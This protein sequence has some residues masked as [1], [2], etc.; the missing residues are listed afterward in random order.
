MA[1]QRRWTRTAHRA[2]AGVTVVV[3]ATVSVLNL[4]GRIDGGTALRLFLAVEVPMLVVFVVLTVLRLRHVVSTPAGDDRSL[5]D[6]VVAEEPLLRP[7]VSELRYGHSLVLAVA[8]RRRVPAGATPFGYTRGTMGVPVAIGVASLVEVV[9]VH[10]LVPWQW[11]R[12]ILLVLSIWGVLI[13]AGY[14]ASRVVHPHLVID[15]RLHLRWGRMTVLT[16]PL[17]NVSSVSRRA[18]HAHTQPHV[19]G[20]R[21]IL[22]QFQ[23][24]N[25]VVRFVD[26]V[27][28]D[29]PVST[30]ERP[31]DVQVTEVQLYVDDPERFRR[32]VGPVVDGAA[33]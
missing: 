33:A 22:T 29:A 15:D 27:S 25:V 26:P 20:D 12:M 9:V 7:A 21:M 8:G 3:L 5:L 18:N 10:L 23:S 16:T 1:Q 32:V 11:L 31:A 4:T 17:A 14:F 2:H 19:D 30:K 28:A 24:T 6:R 13:L